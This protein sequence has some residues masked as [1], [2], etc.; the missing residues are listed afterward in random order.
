MQRPR[1][2]CSA[3]SFRHSH[4]LARVIVRRWMVMRAMM[5]EVRPGGVWVGA[6][7]EMEV[8]ARLGHRGDGRF[9]CMGARV[10]SLRV[11]VCD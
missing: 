2:V 9:R 6:G 3:Q 7:S 4:R 5:R 10:V 8:R 1:A 11:R